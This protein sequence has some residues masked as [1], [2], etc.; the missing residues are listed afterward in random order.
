M[1]G[2]FFVL[3]FYVHS[4][5]L[6]LQAT[7]QT[8]HQIISISPEFSVLV[9]A[10]II[11]FQRSEVPLPFIPTQTSKEYLIV[12]FI[13]LFLPKDKIRACFVVLIIGLQIKCYC[14]TVIPHNGRGQKRED[15]SFVWLSQTTQR[16][17]SH[18]RVMK[19]NSG[20]NSYLDLVC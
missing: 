1:S 18:S 6:L 12:L 5:A 15:I 3:F 2:G 7:Q 19:R 14:G 20:K 4:T 13:V 11:I 17:Q 10:P 8:S 9:F 16:I